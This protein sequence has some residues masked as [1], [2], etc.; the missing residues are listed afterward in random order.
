MCD[1]PGKSKM[2]LYATHWD[3]EKELSRKE[4]ERNK[5]IQKTNEIV[6]EG[7]DIA[8]QELESSKVGNTISREANSL[9]SKAGKRSRIAL[10]VQIGQALVAL[11][12]F[13]LSIIALCKP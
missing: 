11:A 1:Y 8:N 6:G 2:H 9:S 12:A 4:S 10:I 5:L 7:N 13:V 3:T